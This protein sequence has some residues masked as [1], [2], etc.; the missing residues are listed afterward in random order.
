MKVDVSWVD[1]SLLKIISRNLI[2]AACLWSILIGNSVHV[3]LILNILWW[4]GVLWRV[5]WFCIRLIVVIISTRTCLSSSGRC[6]SLRVARLH[7]VLLLRLLNL[8]CVIVVLGRCVIRMLVRYL[9][10]LSLICIA[11]LIDYESS[12]VAFVWLTH[13]ANL[14]CRPCRQLLLLLLL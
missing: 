7:V 1:D 8:K 6:R 12:F 14:L 13:C 3:S 11:S 2:G 4:P 9:L 10:N 5:R